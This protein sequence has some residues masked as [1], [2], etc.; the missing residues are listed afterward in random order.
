MHNNQGYTEKAD[1]WSYGMIL[2]E[3]T[4][5]RIPYDYCGDDPACLNEEICVHQRKP[6]IPD[7]KAI[8]PVLLKLM[9]QCWMF[10]PNQRPSFNEIITILKKSIRQQERNSEL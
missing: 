1:V 7:V 5:N 8:H 2:Y 4:T 3:I 10:D 6:P 9:E